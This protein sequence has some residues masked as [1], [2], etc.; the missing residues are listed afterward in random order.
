M[1]AF[2]NGDYC[3]IGNYAPRWGTLEWGKP[4]IVKGCLSGTMINKKLTDHCEVA[5]DGDKLFACFCNKKSNCNGGMAQRKLDEE[6]IPL[7]Q[8][9]CKGSHCK[10][11]TCLGELC[12]YVI[13]HKTKK[14][15]QGCVNASIPLIE[16][17][18]AGSCMMPPITGAMHH[19]VAKTAEDLLTTE[20]CVCGTDFC[21][22]EKPEITTKENMKCPTSVKAE[23]MGTKMTSRNVS[24]TG[25]Y[26]Y[27]VRIRSELGHMTYYDTYGC[28]SFIEGAELAEEVNPVGCAK[29]ESENLKVEA[30][31]KTND[32]KAIQR[33]K[34]NAE[35]VY[36]KGSKGKYG[37][38]PLKMEIEEEFDDSSD[39]NGGEEIEEKK[40]VRERGKEKDKNK[41]NKEEIDEDKK[42]EEIEKNEEENKKEENE[43]VEKEG[44]EEEEENEEEDEKNDNS[45]DDEK[46]MSTPH[47]IFERVTKPPPEDDSNVTLIT[48]FVLVI[49]LILLS[50]A[51]WK[52]ELHKKLMRSSYDTVAG[53]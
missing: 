36:R 1:G 53:G 43:D 42:E 48:V 11:K 22:S 7:L 3:M 32:K 15:E 10:G 39:D 25:E 41:N 4:Q 34:A 5:E 16:R 12:S 9:A 35:Q 38:K 8:C 2:C 14:V 49:L 28:V 40:P 44:E 30:C 47:Y 26:C 46:E 17:R 23:V 19:T 20:S 21:N 33:A 45:N 6:P 29:F 24:C 31:F 51:V 52:L 50:G 37:K 18:T 13:N 27:K